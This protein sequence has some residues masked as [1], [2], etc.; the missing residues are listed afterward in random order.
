MLNRRDIL[1]AL[2]GGSLFVFFEEA[3]AKRRIPIIRKVRYS[4]TEERTRIVFDCTGKVERKDIKAKLKGSTIWLTIRNVRSNHLVRKLKSPLVSRAEVI[5]INSHL[6]RIKVSMKDPHKFKVFALKSCGHKPFR[7][8]VDVLSDFLTT[9]C[10][11]RKQKKRIVVIDPGHGGKD[12]GAVWPINS[13]H[14]RIKEKDITLSIALRVRRILKE[15]PNIEVIMTRTRDVYVPLLKRAEIA[16]KSCADAFVSIHAD[17]MPNFPNWSG[18]TVFKASPRLF[19]KAQLVAKKVAQKVRLCNDV[20]CWSI[21]PLLIS[22]ATT[23]TFVESARLAE[24]IVE[25]LKAHVNEDL[26]NGIR[27]MRRN[28]LVLKTPGRPAV[29]IESG[30][31]TN[32]KDRKRLVQSWYQEEVARGI[33]R[34]IVRY[35]ESLNPVAYVKE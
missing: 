11:T 30:F 21:S 6:V 9:E 34:G 4:S 27:D 10:E 31:L 20:M 28:I 26:V 22:M 18:V 32:P 7:I 33:A 25:S 16:A 1:K 23:V 2:A 13:Y 29:L 19:A 14:P 3:E 5:P 17:S 24:A 15:H 35:F 12:P 8:V